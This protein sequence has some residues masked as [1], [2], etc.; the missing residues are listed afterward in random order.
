MLSQEG[1]GREGSE[2]LRNRGYDLR[3]VIAEGRGS[4]ERRHSIISG[5]YR[6]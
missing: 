6:R 4:G 1:R 5:M 3:A 2:A